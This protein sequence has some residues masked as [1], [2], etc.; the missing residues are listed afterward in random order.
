MLLAAA[1]PEH[2]PHCEFVNASTV[3]FLSFFSLLS[4][5]CFWGST[6]VNASHKML[7][8]VN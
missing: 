1:Q 2:Y 3:T 6:V 4:L 8:I 7:E 5:I